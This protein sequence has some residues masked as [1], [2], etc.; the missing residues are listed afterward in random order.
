MSPTQTGSRQIFSDN[1]CNE[2]YHFIARLMP[3]IIVDGFEMIDIKHNA[4]EICIL[5][6]RHCKNFISMVLKCSSIVTAG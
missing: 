1:I 6:A 3:E 4:A 5:V 2:F